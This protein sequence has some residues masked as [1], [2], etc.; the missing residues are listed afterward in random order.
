MIASLPPGFILILGGLLAPLVPAR[1]R[2]AYMLTLPVLGF[3]HLLGLDIGQY[4]L[5][6]FFTYTLVHVR[7]PP[8]GASEIERALREALR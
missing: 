1:A 2:P 4:G 3:I 6:E 5:I 8:H 7:V